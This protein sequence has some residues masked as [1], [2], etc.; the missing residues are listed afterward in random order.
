MAVGNVKASLG[1]A[2]GMDLRRVDS[3]RCAPVC[4]LPLPLGAPRSIAL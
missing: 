3:A 4:T 2:R 1:T